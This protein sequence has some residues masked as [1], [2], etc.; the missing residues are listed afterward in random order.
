MIKHLLRVGR[1]LLVLLL[2]L[3]LTAW[4]Q[5]RKVSGKIT[6]ADYGAGIPGVNIVEKG[7][8]NGAVS[9]ADGN[10]SVSVGANA[11]LVFS[12]IGY[13]TQE[14]VVGAQ[15]T[16]DVTLATDVT[17]LSEIVVVGYGTQEK[18]E[19]TSSVSSVKS[20]D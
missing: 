11:T 14:V 6:G 10:Y 18:K 15:N 7:T 9:D 19:I 17:A 16:I 12:A 8:T 20:E 13:A 3:S 1:L 2:C 4:A 5:E